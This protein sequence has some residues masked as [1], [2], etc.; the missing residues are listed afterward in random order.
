MNYLLFGGEGFIGRH[1]IDYLINVQKVPSDKVF[2]LDI[3]LKSNGK[4]YVFTDVR[5]EITFSIPGIS[6]SVIFN[7]AAIHVTPG[8]EDH[9]YFE[10]NIKG[11]ENICGFAEKNN[12]PT[13]VFTSSIA[14]YGPSEEIKPESS[15]PMP[16]T[17][18]GI[19]K[20]VAEHIFKTWQAGNS[21][22]RKL[23]IARPGVVFGKN[24]G[25]NFTRL[26]NAQNKGFFFYPGRK[27]TIKACIYIKDAVRILF[28]AINTEENNKVNIYNL[29]YSPAPTIEEICLSISEVTS[30]S[31][32]RLLV[33][34][35][36][37][38]SV[39]SVIYSLGWMIGKKFSGIHPDRVKKLMIS[40]NVSGEKLQNSSY[41]IQF[42]LKEAI[43]DWYNT[44]EKKGLL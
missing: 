10:T 22:E 1:L 13:I 23:F 17:P 4:N 15:L 9:E 14:P 2:S 34:A 39:A 6:H 27:D 30:V 25:G 26:Y 16:T 31:K 19:S 35:F 32:P 33:P 29:T 8:H 7:L 12:I 20:L 28:S 44:S 38:K 11:A 41:R 24:E 37:L 21:Q 5:K 43:Q 36:F 18:Y 40:T 3:E 42:S